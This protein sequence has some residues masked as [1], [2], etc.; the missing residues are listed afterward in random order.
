MQKRQ[1]TFFG[2]YPPRT[3]DTRPRT[4]WL[5]PALAAALLLAYAAPTHA[6][7]LQFV[8]SDMLLDVDD[9]VEESNIDSDK[10]FAPDSESLMTDILAT[11]AGSTTFPDTSFTYNTSSAAGRFGAIGISSTLNGST[12]LPNAQI[13][14]G[15]RA[16]I[17]SDEFVN[18]TA[19]P[20][21][22]TAN[23]II[24][25]GSLTVVSSVPDVNG[26]YDLDVFAINLGNSGAVINDENFS[27][28]V[29]FPA[30]PVFSTSGTLTTD[31][32]G[33]ASAQF[34]GEDIGAT[35]NSN[36]ITIPL[37]FQTL[38][39]GIMQPGDRMYVGYTFQYLLNARSAEFISFNF[40]DPLAVDLPGANSAFPTI[41]LSDVPEPAT[42]ATLLI[43]LATTAT[44]RRRTRRTNTVHTQH[45]PNQ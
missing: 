10:V 5:L 8:K 36:T 29:P 15:G 3:P 2:A 20:Q 35:F 9:N 17:A 27:F 26:R 6:G 44:P 22:A 38:D 13:E 42:A 18:L 16:L 19:I 1:T 14:L 43:T 12:S 23:F 45:H 21:Q 31:Q 24:D 32:S 11:S 33:V 7:V 30:D 41:T 37:S 4:R 34:T 28:L 40:S 25:G 39:L